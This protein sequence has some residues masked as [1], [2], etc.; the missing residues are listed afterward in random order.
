MN[1]LSGA[2]GASASVCVVVL[3]AAWC[4]TCDAY[5][6]VLASVAAEFPGLARRW[7]D[8]EDEA[9]LL[10]ELDVETFPSVLVFDRDA[11]RFFG[12][13]TPQPETLRRLL[14]ATLADGRPARDLAP[15]VQALA[16]R[17]RAEVLA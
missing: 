6:P 11:V 15:E 12:P 8:I 9:E 5:A 2:G 10:G 1:D 4:R 17:L 13:L 7:L 14:R 16:E 3:C